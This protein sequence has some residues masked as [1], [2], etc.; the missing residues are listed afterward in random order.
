M[1][2]ATTNQTDISYIV[3]ASP[4]TIPTT[5]AFTIL[6]TTGGSPTAD[7]TTEVS[8]IIRSDRQI[9]DLVPVDADVGGDVEYEVA[10]APFKPLFIQLLRNTLSAPISISESATT[11]VAGSTITAAGATFVTDGVVPGQFLKA[12]GF[13]DPNNNRVYRVDS[14]TETELTVTPAPAGDETATATFTGSM[15]RNGAAAPILNTFVK[16]IRTTSDYFFYYIDSLVNSMTLNFETGSILSGTM[17]LMGTTEDATTTP[18]AGQTFDDP[19]AYAIMNSVNNIMEIGIEGLP[20]GTCFQTMNLTI[21]NN[22][23]GAKCIGTLGASE[24]QDFGWEITADIETYF[25]DLTLYDKFKNSQA[26]SV[27]VWLKDSLGNEMVLS[28][29]V[30]KFEELDIPIPGKDEF[31]TMPGSL[32]ALRD[33]TNDYTVQIDFFDAP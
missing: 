24:N 3:Q 32:R 30:C 1:P 4:G 29:P 22:A 18:V 16:R 7:I 11:A 14:L 9:D 21:N 12:T 2:K 27:Y 26:F 5:P 15:V 28:M 13:T 19:P 10:Y 23:E 25:E 33:Q 8:A 20:A 6:P 17:N 31:L